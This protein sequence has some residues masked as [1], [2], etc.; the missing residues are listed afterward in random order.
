MSQIDF[1]IFRHGE[2]DWNLQK[3]FQGHTDIPLNSSGLVQAQELALAF[4][5][6]PLDLLVTSDLIRAKSTA[7]AVRGVSPAPLHIDARL[8]ECGLGEA[9]GLYRDEVLVKYGHEM[10]ERWFSVSSEDLDF[11]FPG[12]ESRGEHLSRMRDCLEEFAWKHPFAKR[13]GVSTHGGSLRRLVHASE[14]APQDPVP[15]PNCS[16]YVLSFEL[17]S[18]LWRFRQRMK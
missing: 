10:M 16:L 12:G 11:R 8:R 6:Y 14:N 15:I 9:E 7:D 18:R 4:Q 17:S 2:T 5:D 13:I 1:F 3:K